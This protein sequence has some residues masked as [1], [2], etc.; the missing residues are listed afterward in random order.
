[1]AGRHVPAVFGAMPGEP[2]G[3]GGPEPP[4]PGAG[5]A[6]LLRGHLGPGLLRAGAFGA[7]GPVVFRIRT[8]GRNHAR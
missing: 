3:E 8:R 6:S 4:G 2:T 5:P 7:V 1:E